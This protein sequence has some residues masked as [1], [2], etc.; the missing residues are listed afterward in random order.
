MHHKRKIKDELRTCE[1]TKSR[2]SE[3]HLW[4]V[5]GGDRITLIIPLHLQYKI[6]IFYDSNNKFRIDSRRSR[7][8]LSCTLRDRI[9]LPFM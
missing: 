4:K 5:S 8:Q 2:Q 7:S 6:K 3:R 9:Q 1:S